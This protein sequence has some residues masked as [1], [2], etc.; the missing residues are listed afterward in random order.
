[1]ALGVSQ[2]KLARLSGVSR[3]KICLFE[4][5]DGSLTSDEQIRIREALL[6]EAERLRQ[7]SAHFDFG[8]TGRSE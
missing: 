2:S 6:V 3:F 1:M 8:W 4:L 7:I 5:G